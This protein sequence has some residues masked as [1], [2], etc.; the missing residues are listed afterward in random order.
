[1]KIE[2][3]ETK[4]VALKGSDFLKGSAFYGRISVESGSRPFMVTELGVVDLHAGKVYPSNTVF[5]VC[6]NAVVSCRVE[7]S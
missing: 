5:S 7:C 4:V 6:S 2:R 1:M 3:I